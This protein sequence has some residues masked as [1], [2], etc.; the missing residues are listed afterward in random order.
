[1]RYG[2][3]LWVGKMKVKAYLNYKK[4]GLREILMVSVNKLPGGRYLR[5]AV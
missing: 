3:T 1:L 5:I 4:K 2:V